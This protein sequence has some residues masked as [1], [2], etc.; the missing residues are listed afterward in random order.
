MTENSK[1]VYYIVLKGQLVNMRIIL[2]YL[3]SAVV[4]WA[5]MNSQ[6]L[7]QLVV[8][9]LAVHQSEIKK[10]R[11]AGNRTQLNCALQLRLMAEHQTGM[12]LP[13]SGPGEASLTTGHTVLR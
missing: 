4:I 12:V 10:Q 3:L 8:E 11:R 13:P 1:C 9:L 6:Q 7:A 5:I 2:K